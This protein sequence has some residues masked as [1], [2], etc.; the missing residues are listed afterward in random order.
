MLPIN[1]I[2][3][4]WFDWRQCCFK[5]LLLHDFQSVRYYRWTRL[6]RGSVSH[7]ISPK[8]SEPDTGSISRSHYM[9][10]KIGSFET[11]TQLHISLRPEGQCLLSGAPLPTWINIMRAMASHVTGVSVVY[12]IVYSCADQRK[13]SK[14]RVTGLC[15]WDSPT[16][17]W[18]IPHTNAQYSGRCFHWMT[19]SL[20]TSVISSWIKFLFHSQT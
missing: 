6:I 15:G 10:R 19:S 18:W 9:R 3:L 5:Y 2:T 4:K 1:Y 14:L 11:G 20:V 16:G 17:E 12:S 13:K 8:P 7:L